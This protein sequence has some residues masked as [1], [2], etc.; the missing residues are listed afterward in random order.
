MLLEM[1][2]K[3]RKSWLKTENEPSNGRKNRWN[4]INFTCRRGQRSPKNTLS[5][6][7]SNILWTADR[8]TD[9]FRSTALRQFLRRRYIQKRNSSQSWVGLAQFS[10]ELIKVGFG[11]ISR[12]WL[13]LWLL[14]FSV[15]C[16]DGK[17][18]RFCNAKNFYRKTDYRTKLQLLVKKR[19]ILHSTGC[20]TQA[21]VSWKADYIS[22][23]F[24]SGRK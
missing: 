9:V 23:S 18:G 5:D 10:A 7:W 4:S 2:T 19:F 24:C 15:F 14:R 8:Q 12:S 1:K 16:W 3:S 11:L 21:L 20:E 17:H 22:N 13:L 6:P